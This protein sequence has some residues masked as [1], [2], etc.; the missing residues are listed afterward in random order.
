MHL[1]SNMLTAAQRMAEILAEGLDIRYGQRVTSIH[2][3]SSG[4]D[5]ACASGEHFHADAVIVTVSL[6]VLK[7]SFSASYRCLPPLTQ[8]LG[9]VPH[10]PRLVRRKSTPGCSSR[11]CQTIRQRPSPG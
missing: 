5:V 11:L 3:S 7:A 10:L 8:A 4:V 6:G 2:W 1:M 9:D